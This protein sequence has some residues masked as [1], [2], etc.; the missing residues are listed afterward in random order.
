MNPSP[1]STPLTAGSENNKCDKVDSTESKKG[2]PIPGIAFI[3]AHSII[4]PTE[5]PSFFASNI[6]FLILSSKSLFINGNSSFLKE[7]IK[8]SSIFTLSKKSS[9]TFPICFICDT[10]FIP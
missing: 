2:L 4:P 9:L 3:I 5:S 8:L 6:S 7:S 1:N 10:I